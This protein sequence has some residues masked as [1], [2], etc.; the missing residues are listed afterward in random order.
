M[1][2]F[3]GLLEPLILLSPWK[4]IIEKTEQYQKDVAEH[5]LKSF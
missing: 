2:S 1:S 3:L 5:I 4:N